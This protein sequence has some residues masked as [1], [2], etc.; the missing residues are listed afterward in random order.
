LIDGGNTS[1]SGIGPLNHARA[2]AK[3][4]HIPYRAIRNSKIEWG[5]RACFAFPFKSLL[6]RGVVI[7]GGSDWPVGLYNPLIG[8]D[9][10]V[11]HRFG[12]E[13][14]GEVLNSERISQCARGHSG[15]YLQRSLHRF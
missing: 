6:E 4:K 2:F 9:I 5:E 1:G 14:K 11:N 12:P 10:L 13:E 15:L 3:E 7:C 8:L